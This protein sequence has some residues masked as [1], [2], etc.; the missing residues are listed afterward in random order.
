VYTL[1]EEWEEWEQIR[2]AREWQRHPERLSAAVRDHHLDV[3]RLQQAIAT[4]LAT[5]RCSLCDASAPR[6]ATIVWVRRFI[7]R[8]ESFEPP[9]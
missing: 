1:P 6:R 4:K 3:R 9:A 7:R 5:L 2:K 8:V